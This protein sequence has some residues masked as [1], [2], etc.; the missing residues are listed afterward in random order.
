MLFPSPGTTVGQVSACLLP[1]APYVTATSEARAYRCVS[2]V[3]T[4]AL[5]PGRRSSKNKT[6]IYLGQPV[7]LLVFETF[8]AFDRARLAICD[9]AFVGF[10][11]E[12][13]PVSLPPFSAFRFTRIAGPTPQAPDVYSPIQA[14]RVTPGRIQNTELPVWAPFARETTAPYGKAAKYGEQIRGELMADN[15]DLLVLD[16]QFDTQSVDP[17]FLEPETGL[18]FYNEQPGKLELVL[19]VQSPHEATELVAFLLGRGP[20]PII[21]LPRRI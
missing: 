8:D 17:M 11:E 9:G 3:V 21:S 1:S 15:A 12:T 2:K 13:G 7:A 18:A 4:P 10:G 20:M 5:L 16:R 14:G 6:P 19:G